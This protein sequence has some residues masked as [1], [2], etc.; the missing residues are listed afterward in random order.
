MNWNCAEDDVVLSKKIARM[1]T[2]LYSFC[3]D[4][5]ESYWQRLREMDRPRLTMP[6]YQDE[7]AK[8]HPTLPPLKQSMALVAACYECRQ[9]SR[10]NRVTLYD[11]SRQGYGSVLGYCRGTR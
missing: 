4:V 10:G 1:K 9:P 7:W 8:A 2:L 11:I 3:P 6:P 5:D